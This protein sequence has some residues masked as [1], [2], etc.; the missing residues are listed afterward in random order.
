MITLQKM[1]I[2]NHFSVLDLVPIGFELSSKDHLIGLGFEYDV[3]DIQNLV[4]GQ[5][6]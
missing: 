4:M 6:W 3:V 2:F 1:I 5:P